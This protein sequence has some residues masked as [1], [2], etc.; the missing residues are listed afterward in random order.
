MLIGDAT[1]PEALQHAGVK[2]A[3]R[4]VAVC[5][6]DGINGQIGITVHK[7]RE[8]NTRP[9]CTVH[10][11]DEAVCN[12]LEETE[13][14]QSGRV[15]Y[16]NIYRSAPMVLRR[17]YPDS[18]SER[19]GE[20]PHIIIAGT[21]EMG[22]RFVVSAAREWWFNHQQ[23]KKK[24]RIALLAPDAEDRGKA[25]REQY[26]HFEDACDFEC[27]SYDLTDA[28]YHEGGLSGPNKELDGNDAEVAV[29]ALLASDGWRASTVFVVYPDERDSLAAMKSLVRLSETLSRSGFRPSLRIKVVTTGESSSITPF[30]DATLL[31]DRYKFVETLPLLDKICQPRFF[32]SDLT[33]EIA[34]A[35]HRRYLEGEEERDRQRGSQSANTTHVPWDDLDIESRESNFAQA[36]GYEAMVRKM[37]YCIEI[38]DDWDPDL[39]EFSDNRSKQWRNTNTSVGSSTRRMAVGHLG[40]GSRGKKRDRT[41]CP[42]KNS[43]T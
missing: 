4:V 29:R 15:H 20:A 22:T 2:H 37:G 8:G 9:K 18:F 27:H 7:L 30:L 25:L 35:F 43:I 12:M 21:D 42:G 19:N 34:K 5:G 10:I 31:G 24:M 6:N 1:D 32:E 11:D 3:S 17:N 41:W 40:Q 38:T 33:E 16:L 28:T 39:P 36:S 14:S 13:M 23:A 26:P